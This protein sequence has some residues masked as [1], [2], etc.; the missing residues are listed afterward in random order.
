MRSMLLSRVHLTSPKTRKME[1]YFHP[2]IESLVLQQWGKWKK[3]IVIS[4]P[5]LWFPSWC[6]VMKVACS[7][8]SKVPKHEI[9]LCRN[10]LTLEWLQE[11]LLI[12]KLYPKG[13]IF[14]EKKPLR[15]KILTKLVLLIKI[16]NKSKLDLMTNLKI[17]TN[18]NS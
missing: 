15:L 4:C 16:W 13:P 11:I 12:S 8:R 1:P 18:L 2:S 9:G 14:I 5:P 6:R 17:K 3:N 7:L 10:N